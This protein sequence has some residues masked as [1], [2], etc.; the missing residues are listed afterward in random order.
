L[1]EDQEEKMERRD[2]KIM[3]EV[4]ELGLDEEKQREAFGLLLYLRR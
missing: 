3:S 4:S 2:E 1:E